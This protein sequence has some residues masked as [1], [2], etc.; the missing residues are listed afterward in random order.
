MPRPTSIPPRLHAE[1]LARAGEGLNCADIASWLGR[2]HNVK[3]HES[4]V[5]RLLRKVAAERAPIAKA[6]VTEQLSKTLTVDLSS[7]NA[8]LKRSVSNEAR[9]TQLIKAAGDEPVLQLRAMEQMRRERAEQRSLLELRFRLSGADSN[10]DDVM[11]RG[12]VVL[13]AETP[14]E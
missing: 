14:D 3:T 6:V 8:L 9:C 13:P 11:P 2:E 4:S 12:L 5:K 1:V 10:D 7:M